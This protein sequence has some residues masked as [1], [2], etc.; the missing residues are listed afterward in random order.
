VKLVYFVHDLND[1][2]VKR[3]AAML[4]RGGAEAV[5]VGFQRPP[6]SD[7]DHSPSI[8]FGRTQSGPLKRL[9]L[10]G[11]AAARLHKW[12]TLIAGAD[13]IMGRTL[14]MV[15]LAAMA[16]AR[17]A[18]SARLVYEC[19]DVH[20][21]MLSDNPLGVSLRQIEAK[22]LKASDLLVVSSQAFVTEYFA[23]RYSYLPCVRLVENKPLSAEPDAGIPAH[24]SRPTGPPWR[25]GWFGIIRCRR[26]L[27]LLESICRKAPGLVEVEIRGRPAYDVLPDFQERVAQTQGMAFLGGYEQKELDKLYN[28]IHFAWAV[29]Y[30]EHPGNSDWLLPNRLYEGSLHG[31]IPIAIEKTAT[32][33]WLMSN[34][35][36][37]RLSEPDDSLLAAYLSRLDSAGYREALAKVAQIPLSRVVCGDD[38]CRNLVRTLAGH[39]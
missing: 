35:A 28:T 8:S 4:R 22:V 17:F 7:C 16:R 29:D 9:P 13:V 14:E 34:D 31:A 38:E 5:V 27:S 37:V 23:K 2:A 11:M 15:S 25:I 26:S 18:P 39:V 32:A 21:M 36:G 3:R 30:F 20:R 19:L 6:Y 12:R 24:A 1:P 33:D 10:L